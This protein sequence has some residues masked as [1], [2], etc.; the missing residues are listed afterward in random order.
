[1][2][3]VKKKSSWDYYG[4]KIIK[5]ILIEGEPDPNLIDETYEDDD[6]QTF[7]ES[8]MLVRAQSFD[9]AYKIAEKKTQQYEEPHTNPYGQQVTWKFI[10]AV[11]C[12]S[13]L[14]EPVSGTE[15]YS[16]FHITD[17]NVTAKDF[18]DKWFNYTE[19]GFNKPC[20]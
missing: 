15:V 10:A 4:V 14:E 13:I 8:V 3:V 17:K 7:E 12:F 1:M 5:Q 18:L 16:C 19:D 2:P 11:D 20:H 9:H 6:E